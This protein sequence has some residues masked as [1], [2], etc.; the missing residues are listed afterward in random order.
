M[1]TIKI[2]LKCLE[3]ID[4]FFELLYK[5]GIEYTEIEEDT[6]ELDFSNW[7]D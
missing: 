3:D 5:H 1:K 7:C 6:Y 4:A 2:K